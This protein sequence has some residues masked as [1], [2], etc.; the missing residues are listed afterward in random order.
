[1]SAYERTLKPF[2]GWVSAAAFSVVLKFP[3]TRASFVAS[4]GGEDVV[5][6]SAVVLVEK[7]SPL[8]EEIDSFLT[9]EGL[10]D[11]TKV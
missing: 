9:E 8:L 5:K 1:M 11:P 4:I 10:N 7:F 2:H 3:P 6:T